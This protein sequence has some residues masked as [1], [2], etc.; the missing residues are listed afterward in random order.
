MLDSVLAK[1][2]NSSGYVRVT[3]G[4]STAAACLSSL[5]Y[6]IAAAELAAL[7]SYLLR[8]T[9]P[10]LVLTIRADWWFRFRATWACNPV[11]VA[12][13]KGFGEDTD[14]S[15]VQIASLGRFYYYI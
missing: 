10:T 7:Y 13:V 15:E 9:V 1:Y 2:R 14:T 8:R 12:E 5:L 11:A 6:G 3:R 4:N